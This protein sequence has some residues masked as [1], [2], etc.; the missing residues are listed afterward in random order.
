MPT[1]ISVLIVDDHPAMRMGLCAFVGSAAEMSVVGEAGDGEEAVDL[2]AEVRPDVVVLD[3]GLPDRD[4]EEVLS[5]LLRVSP[6]TKVLILTTHAGEDT[7]RR[8]MD[9]GASGYVM[10]DAARAQLIDAIRAVAAGRRVLR[11]VVAERFEN[12]CLQDRLTAR[13]LDVLRVLADG[14]SNRSIGEALGIAEQTVKI[15]IG[16][17]IDKLGA[18]DRTDAVVTAIER[19]IV[20]PGHL[21]AREPG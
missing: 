13:E 7:I 11:G 21:E 5:D 16:K 8:V 12:A 18:R 19:G 10:K 9:K 15:H 4:G 14:Q 17:I 6:A 1:D 20:P 2:G 3:L